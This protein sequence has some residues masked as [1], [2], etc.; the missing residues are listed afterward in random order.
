ME[1]TGDLDAPATLRSVKAPELSTEWEAG[2]ARI[3][4]GCF[5]RR[6]TF[7]CLCWEQKSGLFSL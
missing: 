5:W 7:A 2:W 1:L 6:R 3:R 4:S